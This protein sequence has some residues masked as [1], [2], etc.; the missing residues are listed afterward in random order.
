MNHYN[1]R[2]QSGPAEMD[3]HSQMPLIFTSIMSQDTDGASRAGEKKRKIISDSKTMMIDG[4]VCERCRKSKVKCD[5]RNPCGRCARLDVKCTPTPPSRR[6]RKQAKTM[7]SCEGMVLDSIEKILKKEKKPNTVYNASK[8]K[9]GNNED[10]KSYGI[11]IHF[12]I[13]TWIFNSFRRRS[14]F[15]LAKASKLAC[16]YDISLDDIIGEIDGPMSTLPSLIFARSRDN[17]KIDDLIGR[18][19][20]LDDF[21]KS[22]L[23]IVKEFTGAGKSLTEGGDGLPCYIFG[24]QSNKGYMRYFFT[25]DFEKDFKTDEE[26]PDFC[27]REPCWRPIFNNRLCHDKIMKSIAGA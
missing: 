4:T 24:R 8:S 16:Q 13:R 1:N 5:R 22:H 21:D 14:T 9:A 17:L 18:R 12:L 15:L 20:K 2:L 26:E 23:D 11:G 10:Q 19:L 7:E 6:G 27:K 25:A 3:L